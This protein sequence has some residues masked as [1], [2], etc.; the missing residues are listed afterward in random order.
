MDIYHNRGHA[1]AG[2]LSYRCKGSYGSFILIGARTNAE[3]WS[4]AKRSTDM[5]HD[6]EVLSNGVWL[7]IDRTDF[8]EELQSQRVDSRSSIQLPPS[9]LKSINKRRK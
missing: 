3:A 2:F 6:M 1:S 7:P 4:E 8:K 5:P 9:L